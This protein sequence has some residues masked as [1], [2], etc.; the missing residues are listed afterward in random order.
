[1]PT[2]LSAS[3]AKRRLGE[4]ISTVADDGAEVIVENHGRPRA[5][6]IPI[7]AYEQYQHL[8]EKARRAAAFEEIQQIRERVRQRNQDLTQEQAETLA[9][10][11]VREVVEDMVAEGK[12]RFQPSE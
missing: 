2:T 3:E 12:I 9:N 11:F 10:R 4:V 7:D 8:R 6:I 1:M 5:A